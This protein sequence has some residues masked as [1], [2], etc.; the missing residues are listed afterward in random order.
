MDG[1]LKLNDM[2]W[3]N[4]YIVNGFF[5]WTNFKW[6]C[7]E[8]LKTFS[9]EKSFFSSK[10]M[11]RAGFVMMGSWSLLGYIIVHIKTLSPL[12]IIAL[13]APFFAAAGY[14]LTKSEKEK[15]LIEKSAD[16]P[17]S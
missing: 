10:R 15:M 7:R 13:V 11:E 3:I 16:E 6:L 17:K 14:A 1:S 9:G 4:K 2:N 8:I 12:D 5:G